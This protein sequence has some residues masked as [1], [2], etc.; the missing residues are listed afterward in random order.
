MGTRSTPHKRIDIYN[1]LVSQ[2]EVEKT[3]ILE[4]CLDE[5]HWSH[6]M[7]LRYESFRRYDSPAPPHGFHL[8][9]LARPGL[10][11]DTS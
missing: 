11:N 6:N 2:V 10:S 9:E 1:N 4:G 3:D 8:K 5:D 7:K